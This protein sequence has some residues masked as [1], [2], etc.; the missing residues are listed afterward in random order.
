[1]NSKQRKKIGISL[2]IVSVIFWLILFSLPLLPYK[3]KILLSVGTIC[4]IL[5]EVLF[6]LSVFVLGKELYEKYKTRLHPRNWFKKA[7]PSG[8]ETK[9]EGHPEPSTKETQETSL[10]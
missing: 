4:F 7:S 9:T 1:M 6:Y 3:G 2:F 8:K 5:G 10:P